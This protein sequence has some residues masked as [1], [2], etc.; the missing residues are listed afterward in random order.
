VLKPL[1]E[2]PFDKAVTRGEIGD[3][4]AMQGERRDDQGRRRSA[5]D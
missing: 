4:R 3:G 5:P 1:G 2:E